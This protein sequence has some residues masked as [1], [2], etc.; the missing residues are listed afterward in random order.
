MQHETPAFRPPAQNNILGA[1]YVILC[2]M[3]IAVTTL[4]ARSMGPQIAG[5]D[6]LHPVQVSWARFFFGASIL[7][8]LA[9]ARRVAFFQDTH[10]RLHI[11]RNLSGIGGVIG[12]FAAAGLMPLAD[13]TAIS[14]LS[15]LF[16]MVLAVVFLKETVGP[17]RWL[18]AAIAFVGSM[19]LTRPGTDAFQPAAL[20]A[21]TAAA[22]L[23]LEM[24]FIKALSGRER[25]LKILAINNGMAAVIIT[26]LVIP[27]WKMPTGPQ[28]VLMV[29]LGATMISAQSLFLRGI[30]IAEANLAAPFFYTT[31]I[32]AALYGW[33]LFGEVP[34][35][36]TICG[37]AL[38]VSG[39]LLL[40]WRENLARR[41]ARNALAKTD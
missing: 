32:F 31:L 29:V 19:V 39:A 15:P 10:W 7:L 21:F 12:M 34:G 20:I 28:W 33:L 8:P 17:W 16:S 40:T 11:G 4:I 37:A 38:I 1:V 25:P 13:S 9:F 2:C 24:I 5:P 22:F 18:A 27:F 30:A 23:G 14:F 35:I 6:A 41:S 3:L 26:L 36:F